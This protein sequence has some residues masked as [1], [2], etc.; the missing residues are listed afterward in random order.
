M[1]NETPNPSTPA[2]AAPAATPA[3]KTGAVPIG[4]ELV[5]G[6]NGSE[7]QP[8]VP[9]SI[10]GSAPVD[11]NDDSMVRIPGQDQPVRYGDLYKRLQGDYTKKTQAAAAAEKK[12]RAD[13]QAWQQSRQQQEDSLRSTAAAL[14]QRQQQG[15]APAGGD[16]MAKL[17]AAP[18]LDGKTAA[19]ILRTIQTEGFGNVVKAIQDR[20]TVMTQQNSRIVQLERIVQQLSGVHQGSALDSRIGAV[21]KDL[22]IPEEAADWA[23]E[24]YSAYEGDDLDEQFPQILQERWTQLEQ[25]QR[26]R[27]QARVDAN[28]RQP[29]LPGKGGNGTAAKPIQMRGDENAREMADLLWDQIGATEKT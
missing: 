12:L 23:K 28:R 8:G 16:F 1:P 7:R 9:G 21:L 5:S 6:G 10:H 22:D 27:N 14:L 19:Q 11:L 20:D 2:A 17:E 25:L 13:Q 24:I 15:N 26:R 3:P 4:A 29:F 18:Y